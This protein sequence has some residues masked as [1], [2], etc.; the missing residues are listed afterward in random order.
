M[1]FI[2]EEKSFFFIKYNK[3]GRIVSRIH[4]KLCFD[5]ICQII[6]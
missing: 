3:M 2:S 4:I 5:N 6:K 1:E